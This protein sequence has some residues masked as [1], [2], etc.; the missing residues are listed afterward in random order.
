MDL[1]VAIKYG[2]I[3]GGLIV[4]SW[5]IEQPFA[6]EHSDSIGG[7][8]VGYAIMLAALSAVF[9]GIR[10]I[11][12]KKGNIT[13]KEAFLNGLAITLVASTIYALGWMSYV[14][15]FAPNFADN[16]GAGQIEL[17]E[18]KDISAEQKQIEIEQIKSWVETYK[19]PPVMAAITFFEIFPIGLLVTL[20][21]ALILKRK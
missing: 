16:Y 2:A 12:N 14:S 20:I 9:L 15:T 17:V 10:S 21:S 8:L 19:K 4:T 7:E 3:S 6:E 11:R 1:K 5:F 13:F 18:E